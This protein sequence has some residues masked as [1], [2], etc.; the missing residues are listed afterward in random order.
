MLQQEINLYQ[1]LKV[2]SP[3]KIILTWQRLWLGNIAF[4]GWLI[5]V[6]LFSLWHVYYLERKKTHIQKQISLLQNEFL[7][8]KGR[9][10]PAFF[11]NNPDVL[12][13]NI[14]FQEKILETFTNRTLFSQ[15]LMAL[16]RNVVPN[17]WLTKI[18]IMDGGKTVTLKGESLSANQLQLYLQSIMREKIFYELGSSVSN[19]ENIS[20]KDESEKLIFEFNIGKKT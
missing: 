14:L 5:L 19:I 7:Q 3:Q 11:S 12:Q 1:H 13:K 8:V 15:E 4:V 18:H 6:Y 20:K 16:S 2:V 10:L 17:V 9:Y